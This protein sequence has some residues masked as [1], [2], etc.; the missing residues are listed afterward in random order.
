[1][2]AST[3]KWDRRAVDDEYE[4]PSTC[5]DDEHVPIKTLQ[6][7]SGTMYY[8]CRKCPAVGVQRGHAQAVKKENSP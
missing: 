2:A 4:G 7:P 8:R 5:T 6:S 3:I 1:M